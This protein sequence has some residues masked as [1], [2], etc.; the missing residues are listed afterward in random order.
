MMHLLQQ[1]IDRGNQQ[2]HTYCLESSRESSIISLVHQEVHWQQH[3]HEETERRM[4]LLLL[5]HEEIHRYTKR[6][7]LQA[8]DQSQATFLS[9][10]SG[11][12]V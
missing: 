4:L 11:R 3:F 9:L 6:R 2:K 7:I 8:V 1:M 5:D 12:L 10:M